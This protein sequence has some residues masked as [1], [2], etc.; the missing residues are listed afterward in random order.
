M[1]NPGNPVLQLYRQAA[2]ISA[3][4]LERARD[5]DWD[6]V[7]QLNETYLQV[8]ENIR[9]FDH[10]RPLN[11]DDRVTK[12]ELLRTILHNDAVTRDLIMPSLERLSFLIGALHRKRR[13]EQAYQPAHTAE[14]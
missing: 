4:M 13:V 10:E 8:I 14:T 6:S 5:S 7:I 2:D 1:T 11:E 3:H 12:C 9:R